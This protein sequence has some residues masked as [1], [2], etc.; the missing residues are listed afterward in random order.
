MEKSKSIS[1]E[2]S[3]RDNASAS[4]EEWG[5][6]PK[7]VLILLL[8]LYFA[9]TYVISISAGSGREIMIGSINLPLYTLAG[10]FSALSNLCIIFM[11][12]FCGKA[13]FISS[14]IVMILQIPIILMSTMIKGNFTSLPGIFVD[15]LTIIAVIVIYR[16]KRKLEKYQSRLREHAT[17][18]VLTGL[19]NG[20]AMTELIDDL[21]RHDKT[22]ALVNLDI[23]D[24]KGIN[25]TVGF[26]MGNKVLIALAS[27]FKDIADRTDS[28]MNSFVSRING[29][30]FCLL[31][32]EH[33]SEYDIEKNI[34]LYEKAV[35]DKITI[36]GYDF[37]VNASIG[38]AI[39]PDDAADRDS[40]ISCSVAAMKEIK[41]INSSVHVMHFS[42]ELKAENHLII[43]NKVREALEND[44]VFF[45]L[46]PQYDMSHKLRGFEA[47]A[48]LR[49]SD[50]SIISPVEFIP[51]AER[52]G[53]ID[54]LDLAVYNK[55]ASFFGELIGRTGAQIILSINA[56]VKH[57]MKSDF[58]D[59]IRR[60]LENNRIPAKQLEIEI[61]E[62]ILIES[63]EKASGILGE[64]KDMGVKIAIDDFG[65]GYSSLSYL[66][67]FPS[68]T[69]KID[70]SFIDKMNSSD[71]SQKYVE[72]IISLAHVM[73]LETVAEGVETD[74]QLETLRSI[75]CDTIQG[76]VWG[77][78]LPKEEAERL[79]MDLHR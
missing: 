77:R 58:T 19:P 52:L 39:F 4:T 46:Q 72:A 20:I 74:D 44:G 75:N 62:S 10:I 35:T 79:V 51:A 57:M 54:S 28:G 5:Q 16:N 29:D 3:I 60:L 31:I 1:E 49:D 66:N 30:E 40:L 50:G 8:L 69:L 12:I 47:L 22:F 34:K 59:E 37:F 73:D 70:K 33:N 48:R 26:D 36:D 14:I 15:I 2:K 21:I 38:Y 7:G 64:L 18:D 25:D 23:N 71:S 65:T 78:P 11:V 67:S 53:V 76:F 6:A 61:T 68:D 27:R 9:A 43:D 63:A 55:A 13:G 42:S 56:S 32:R 41:R 45:H 24:F 17:T